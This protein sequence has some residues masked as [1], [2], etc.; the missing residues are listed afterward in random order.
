MS[1]YLP[2]IP[3]GHWMR[4]NNK[5]KRL[6]ELDERLEG[7]CEKIDWLE[8]DDKI[9]NLIDFELGTV[10][11]HNKKVWTEVEKVKAKAKLKRPKKLP[12]YLERIIDYVPL[13]LAE[14]LKE[15]YSIC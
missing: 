15:K 4:I 1:A 12:D 6:R 3:S 2:V 8:Y 13:Y 14:T 5:M 7:T 9:K 10:N 11:R